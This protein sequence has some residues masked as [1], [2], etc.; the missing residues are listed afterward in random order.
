MI[1]AQSVSVTPAGITFTVELE[2]QLGYL[3]FTLDTSFGVLDTN[4]LG[5]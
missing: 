4:Y 3:A 1:S 5:V 2:K